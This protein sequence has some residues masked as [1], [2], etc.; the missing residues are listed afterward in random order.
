MLGQ[1]RDRHDPGP[2]RRR[3]GSREHAPEARCCTPTRCRRSP[4]ST[5]PPSPLPA[6]LVSVSAHKFGGPQGVGALV[7]AARRRCGPAARRRPGA[8][9]PQRHPQ[10]GR[11]RGMAAALR[12]RCVA[13]RAATVE[14]VGPS[15]ATAW[16]TAC[17]PRVDGWSRPACAD[18][19]RR[20]ARP[21]GH[22][23]AGSCHLCIEGIESEALLFLLDRPACAPR[24]RRRAPAARRSPS[25]VLAA[26]G[27]PR[28]RARGRCACRSAGPPPTPSRPRRRGGPRA[29]RPPAG[30]FGGLPCGAEGHGR[31]VG[32]RRLVGAA[33]LLRDAGPRGRRGHPE[34]VGRRVRHRLLLGVR[35]RRRPPGRPAA[36]ASTTTCST[37]ATT[38]TRHVVEP[39][40]GRPRRGRTPN[41]CIECNRHLKFDR[42]LRRAEALGFD[43][44]ATGHH[45]RVV[46]A[47][48]APAGSPGRRPG[49]GPVL[50]A[51][52][53]D[54]DQLAAR[55]VPGRRPHQ[56]RGAPLADELGLRTADK[57]D[58]Q[59]VCFI[60]STGGRAGFL[61]DRIELH[62]GGWSTR[63]VTG[64]PGRR[65]RAGHHRPAPGARPPSA[66]PRTCSPTQPSRSRV[67]RP[68]RRRAR[69]TPSAR[70]TAS[71][72]PAAVTV[73]GDVLL[74]WVEPRR[75][76]APGQSVVLYEGDEVVGSATAA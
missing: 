15:C 69:S 33:A 73:D 13:E 35:R 44:V 43:A 60:T 22:K 41:P 36:R 10:R 52:M 56:G 64:R 59:D 51:H 25:H 40:V 24:R 74:R 29:C 53:L 55:A 62:P 50:R 31:H 38:S 21:L 6:D 9:A 37:S 8:R 48:T 19:G 18:R 20:A 76:V 75:R 27:V 54:Q 16:P 58:S 17:G 4:G 42:L 72:R 30:R 65:G 5:S 49:Q 57:P 63:R 23:V 67:G 61:A 28:E 2:R 7:C 12:R 45:A 11:H 32:R 68:V 66:T 14:R 70:P 3:R 47:P 71:P 39:Y 34:A 26:M 1:Q 46:R